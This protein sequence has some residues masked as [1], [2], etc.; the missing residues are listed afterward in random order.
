LLITDFSIS[1]WAEQ[2]KMALEVLGKTD[3]EILAAFKAKNKM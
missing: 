2:A 1:F 3:E